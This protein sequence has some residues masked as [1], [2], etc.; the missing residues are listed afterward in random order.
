MRKLILFG[1]LFL[2]LGTSAQAQIVTPPLTSP[3]WAELQ[4]CRL[5]ANCNIA[6]PAQ[7]AKHSGSNLGK[8]ALI[9]GTV[10]VIAYMVSRNEPK[11]T[12]L[13]VEQ[14]LPSPVCPQGTQLKE[15]WTR[16]I[17][18]ISQCI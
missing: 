16:E 7:A 4:T 18:T 17:G 14:S 11:H 5:A 6:P 13:V 1:V 15:I 12:E 3:I 9:I 8:A 10:A 2:G